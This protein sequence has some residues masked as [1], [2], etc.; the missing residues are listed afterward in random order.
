MG[1]PEGILRGIIRFG[2]LGGCLNKLSGLGG[3][4][5]LVITF[6]TGYVSGVLDTHTPILSS[7]PF[8]GILCYT[9]FCEYWTAIFPPGKVGIIL[10]TSYRTPT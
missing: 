6:K 9:R 8:L 2:G 4:L 5:S 7:L 3:C 10:D 1:S